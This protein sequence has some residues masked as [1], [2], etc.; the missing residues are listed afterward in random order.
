MPGSLDDLRSRV[1]VCLDVAPDS[2][3][4]SLVAAALMPDGRIRVEGI[5]AWDGLGCVDKALRELPGLLARV[6]PK[7]LGWFPS[8]PAAGLLAGLTDPQKAG[9]FAGVTVSEIRG[10][11]SAACMGLADLVTAEQ[12]C[13]NGELLLDAH[14][15]GAEKLPR[16]DG[17]VFSRRGEGHC[18]AAYAA[19]GA[20]Q[21]ARTLPPSDGKPRLAIV[22]DD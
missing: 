1:A 8:G 5:K 13:H 7:T 20:V 2:Q 19:A 3:H 9:R 4:V 21:L 22:T 14:V 17:W 16:G 10:E 15:G 11:T 12:I 6:K 18:D